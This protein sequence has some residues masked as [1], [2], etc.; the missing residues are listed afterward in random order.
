MLAQSLSLC[1]I[2]GRNRNF[3]TATG[4]VLGVLAGLH[5]D[6]VNYPFKGILGTDRHLDRHASRLEAFLH[7]VN[8]P[9]KVSPLLVHLVYKGNTGDLKLIRPIPDL[10]GLDFNP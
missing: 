9:Q 2:V 5:P 10:F 3:F 7:V 4:T 1:Q 8:G 6:Q